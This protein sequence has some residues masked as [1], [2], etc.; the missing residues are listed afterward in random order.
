MNREQKAAVID[1]VATQIKEAEAVFAIDYRGISVPQA[2]TLR[3]RLEEADATLRVVKNTLTERAAD[4]AGAEGLKELLEGPT[5]FTFVR[6]DAALA[7]KVIATFRRENQVLEFK[8]GT[9]DGAV[10]S[11]EQIEAI[12]KLPSQQVLHGQLVGV[13]AS[14]VTGLVRGLHQL[15]QGLASQLGQIADQG[16][17]SGEAPAAATEAPAAETEA[18]AAETEQAPPAETDEAPAAETEEAPPAE[19]APAGDSGNAPSEEDVPAEE[20]APAK[21]DA[22]TA[23]EPSGD[24]P[25]EETET[26]VPSEGDEDQTNRAQ[27][28]EP[29]ASEKSNRAQPAEPAAS[30]EKEG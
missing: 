6:G 1:E 26:V 19:D 22:P 7:A 16:L 3:E 30:Q 23:E 17:V 28:A 11:I 29:A 25:A 14:P 13:L 10:L 24:A 20:D 27:P 15:I 8:G 9:M 21:E 5:A 4:Q 18:P 2:A 12:A